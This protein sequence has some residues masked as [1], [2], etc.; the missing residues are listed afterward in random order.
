MRVDRVFIAG[1]RSQH[2]GERA[3]TRRGIRVAHEHEGEVAVEVDAAGAADTSDGEVCE[4]REVHGDDALGA[5]DVV[6][7]GTGDINGVTLVGV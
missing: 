1:A 4:L 6:S 7:D 3:D 5:V 2:G